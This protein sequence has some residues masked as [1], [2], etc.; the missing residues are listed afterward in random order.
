MNRREFIQRSP[1]LAAAG[2]VA[3][4]WSPVATRAAE[5]KAL[6]AGPA[7]SAAAPLIF[8]HAHLH[9]VDHVEPNPGGDGFRLSRVPPE[10]WTKLNAMGKTRAFAAAGAELRFNLVGPEARVFLRFVENRGGKA[11]GW[12]VLAELYQGGFLMRCV[13]FRET[14]TAIVIK[15]PSNLAKMVEESAGR[16]ADGFDPALVRLA[17][18]Y[19]PETQIL[20]IEGDIAPPRADQVP[21]RS[22]LAY[23]SSI[24]HGSYALRAGE[25]YPAQVGRALDVNVFNLGFGAAAFLEPE[26]AQWLARR[27]DWDFATLEL[28]VNLLR[29][30]STE[31]FA[32]R[33][34]TFLHTIV[35]AHPQRPIFVIDIFTSSK[36]L[37]ANP[38]RTEFRQVVRDTVAQLKSNH[39]RHL[40]GR[41][42]F[43][44]TTGL[45]FDLLHPS[46]DGYNEIASRLTAELQPALRSLFSK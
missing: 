3:A 34:H 37:E 29:P 23:G 6:R 45:C 8:Q 39:V 40:D 2:A 35:A 22:Y 26:M 38:K 5:G 33:A 44:R 46:S 9:N 30:I 14:W 21:A 20:R 4:Q 12:P 1:I 41:R 25:T 31:E 10:V 24:T 43:T 19:M 18:P 15:Q 32:R 13:D 27:R 17:L 7:S 36:E 42:L 11:Q 16:G 28:G